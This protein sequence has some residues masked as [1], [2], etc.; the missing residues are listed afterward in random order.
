VSLTYGSTISTDASSGN[1]FDVTLTGNA[2]LGTPAN[3]TD[4]Q[5]CLW[6]IRRGDGEQ[7]TLASAFVI[8]NGAAIDNSGTT[9]THLYA[10]YDAVVSQWITTL[11]SQ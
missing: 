10:T 11:Y 8:V 7:L 3:P 4:G 1:V 2:T 9:T 5:L 6:R